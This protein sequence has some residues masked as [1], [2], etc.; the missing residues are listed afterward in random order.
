MG[1]TSLGK[2]FE[3]DYPREFFIFKVGFEQVLDGTLD[4]IKKLF[5]S[6]IQ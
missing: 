1:I 4:K 5:S 6:G 2:D 3:K